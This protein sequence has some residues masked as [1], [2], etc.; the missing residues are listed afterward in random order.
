MKGEKPGRRFVFA[1]NMLI[2][3]IDL[4]IWRHHD[5]NFPDIFLVNN[6]NGKTAQL[7]KPAK[8]SGSTM[9][10]RTYIGMINYVKSDSGQTDVSTPDMRYSL[11]K[12]QQNIREYNRDFAPQYPVESYTEQKLSAYGIS[13]GVGLKFGEWTKVRASFYRERY[14]LLNLG[15]AF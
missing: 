9:S 3:K 12:I 2:G 7:S 4:Y 14:T 8:K 11:K 6:E 15:F 10:P 1:K 5:G 13:A